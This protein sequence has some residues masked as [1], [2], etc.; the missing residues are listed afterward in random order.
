[1]RRWEKEVL[2][3]IRTEEAN[4]LQTPGTSTG[5][6]DP[7]L[8]RALYQ[9]SAEHGCA[10]ENSAPNSTA[11]KVFEDW[12][13][14]EG[15]A[16]IAA[17][18]RGEGVACAQGKPATR[19]SEGSGDG[20]RQPFQP[21]TTVHGDTGAALQQQGH[22]A[23]QSGEAGT[24]P[25]MAGAVVGC[26]DTAVASDISE[27]EN[28]E[29]VEDEQG[30]DVIKKIVEKL[31][32]TSSSVALAVA[33]PLS[34]K[35]PPVLEVKQDPRQVKYNGAWLNLVF[36]ENECDSGYSTY[37]FTRRQIC[38]LARLFTWLIYSSALLSSPGRVCPS[39]ENCNSAMKSPG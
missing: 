39:L 26:G 3:T 11:G 24:D 10:G 5:G 20:S 22:T 16:Q 29:A 18:E 1:M 4:A 31:L 14:E 38:V 28:R 34:I 9:L 36:S 35:L 15:V 2:R 33:R 17:Q 19:A 7:E 25:G 8:M 30:E 21:A 32:R 12:E 6:R 23:E 37:T 27:E 13:S